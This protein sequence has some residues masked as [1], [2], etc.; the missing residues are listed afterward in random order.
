M[1]GPPPCGILDKNHRVQ[2]ESADYLADKVAKL[3]GQLVQ[4]CAKYPTCATDKG[5]EYDLTLPTNGLNAN[6][7]HLNVVGLAAVAKFYWPFVKSL[8]AT[9]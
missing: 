5:S 6:N 4:V 1:T 3:N 8:L 7:D 9:G 2:K